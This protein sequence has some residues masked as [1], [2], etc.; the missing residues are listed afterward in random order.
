MT[1]FNQIETL[2]LD[3][4]NLGEGGKHGEKGPPLPFPSEKITDGEPANFSRN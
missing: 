1:F 4:S 2:M 3:S